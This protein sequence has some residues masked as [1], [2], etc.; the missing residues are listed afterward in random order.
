MIF[1]LFFQA[2]LSIIALY[3]ISIVIEYFSVFFLKTSSEKRDTLTEPFRH[4]SLFGYISGLFFQ[5]PHLKYIPLSNIIHL[6]KKQQILLQIFPLLILF[7]FFLIT[8]LFYK[9]IGQYI[10][11]SFL[12]SILIHFQL[13]LL[14]LEFLPLPGRRIFTALCTQFYSNALTKF[15]FIKKHFGILFFIFCILDILLKTN[16]ITYIHWVIESIITALFLIT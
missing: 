7:I 15:P 1:S 8:L 4:I 6:K 16:I 5:L 10:W 14:I 9:Y 2:L 11:I 3:F 12:C 13:S